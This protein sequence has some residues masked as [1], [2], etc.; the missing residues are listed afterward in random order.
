MYDAVFVL[1]EAFSKLLKK[2]PDQFRSYTSR[3]NIPSPYTPNATS[4]HG[5]GLGSSSGSP[6]SNG[7]GGGSSSSNGR[8]L[9][10]NTS[11][12]WEHGDKI[13]RYLRKVSAFSICTL[14]HRSSSF[15]SI[16]SLVIWFFI[17]WMWGW[18]YGCILCYGVLW[19]TVKRGKR[20][21]KR[22]ASISNNNS[23]DEQ[24]SKEIEVK[25]RRNARER[26]R[27]IE[28][29]PFFLYLKI[30]SCCCLLCCWIG[31]EKMFLLW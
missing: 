27:E 12:G 21:A 24:H 6:G 10:C 18:C 19:W 2:K 26:E 1:V 11:K 5:G 25:V 29:I 4:M 30:S 22:P 8:A 13:S 20:R 3:R 31:E 9:D 28:A 14:A 7:N 17:M 23:N 15:D 16:F